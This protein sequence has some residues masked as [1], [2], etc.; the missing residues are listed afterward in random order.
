MTNRID[1][2][3]SY[4]T[5][6]CFSYESTFYLN[7][8]VNRSNMRY[9]SDVNPHVFREGHSQYPEKRKVWAGIMGNHIVGPLF[10]EG[11]LNGQQYLDMLEDLIHPLIVEIAEA[12]PDEFTENIVFQ[13]DG[14]PS[15]AWCTDHHYRNRWIGRKSPTEW[16]AC[17]PDL[18]PTYLK[19]QVYST[20]PQ[21]LADLRQKIID[22]CRGI[23]VETFG[24]A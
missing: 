18:T 19:S 13:Q 3:P 1:S 16:P 14:A 23:S 9:R 5:H 12:H 21:N 2:N 24:R 20:P 11:N 7:G 4:L 6:V 15:P 8:E 17:S 22:G 10:I